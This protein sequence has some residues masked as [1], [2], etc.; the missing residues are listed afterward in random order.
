MH[1]TLQATH[2]THPT[3]PGPWYVTSPPR[4]VRC[5]GMGGASAGQARRARV[6]PPQ[7][8]LRTPPAAPPHP[9]SADASQNQHLRRLRSEHAP[10]PAPARTHPPPD[11]FH[12]PC[13]AA[14]TRRGPRPTRGKAQVVGGGARSQ[15]VHRRVLEQQHRLRAAPLPRRRGL[16]RASH[17]RPLPRP[18]LHNNKHTS[19]ADGLELDWSGRAPRLGA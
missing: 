6:R 5:S 15:R 3:W 14:R 4:S 2:P 9:P 19:E 11:P 7:A 16:E 8:A 17:Q 12:T 10:S 18:G 13:T 1:G